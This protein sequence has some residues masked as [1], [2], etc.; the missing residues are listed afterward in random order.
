MEIAGFKKTSLVDYPGNISAV[1]FLS[2][3]NFRCGFCHNPSIVLGKAA[4]IEEKE[5]MTFLAKRKRVLEGVCVTGGEPTIH[6]NLPLLLK[7]ITSM[8][9]LAKLDTNGTN[10]EML[11]KVIEK[12][13]VDY[14]AMDI[15][16]PL[17]KYLFAVNADINIEKIKESIRILMDSKIEY[18][19]RMTLIPKFVDIK[20]F[21]EVCEMLKGAK[22]FYI[23][24]FEKGNDMI[25]DS[26][27]AEKV[28]TDEELEK[29]LEIAKEYFKVCGIRNA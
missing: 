21:K 27:K 7:K 1:I 2:G 16:A 3:C 26:F 25:D 6:K 5:V 28:Y 10:P 15:K 4:K 11:K 8:G 9:F 22:R 12:G 23:Q 19:F 13:I 29:F 17:E 20:S 24:Q 14:V 18:E